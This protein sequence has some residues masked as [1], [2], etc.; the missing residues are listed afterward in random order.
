MPLP[1]YQPMKA[2]TGELPVGDTEAWSAEVKWDGQRLLAAVG[3]PDR[4]LRLDTT[5]G[6]DAVARFPELAGLPDALAP[7]RLIVD[8][9][10]VAFD[11]Q[12]RPSFGQLQ[13]RMHLAKPADVA[14]VA[15]TIPVSYVIFDLLWLDGRDLTRFPY[16]ERRQ[17][18]A[19]TVRPGEGWMVP[20]Q[21]VGGGADLLKAA[22][23]QRL[24]GIVVKRNTS[25]YVPGKRSTD[26]R[27]VKVRPRQEF[28]VGGW[29]P[30]ERG[31]AGKFGSLLLGVHD[32][33]KLRYAGKV[34]TGYTGQER[35]RVGKLLAALAVDES[36]FEPPPPRVVSRTAHWVR[37]VLVAEV[38]FAEWTSDGTLRHPSYVA[39]RDDKDPRDVVREG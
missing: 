13:H 30:G 33:D 3:S 25:I 35:D 23:A 15:A 12:G 38:A 39:L 32:G 9:E 22:T 26:W 8:G 14:R 5:T 2:V 17:L 4:P 36:P 6:A 11:E 1:K 29:H 16:L 28:V 19:E 20:S 10:A 31:L 34:G 37:P 21:H 24:E 18:L 27:K 7:H